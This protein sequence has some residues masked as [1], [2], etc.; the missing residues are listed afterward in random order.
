MTPPDFPFDH[1]II[2]FPDAAAAQ[3]AAQGPL[4]RLL[5]PQYPQVRFT[6]TSDPFDAR[7]GSGGGTAAALLDHAAKEE[8]VLILHAGG[9]AS[10][11]PT[12]MCLGKAWTSLPVAVALPEQPLPTPLDL[13]LQLCQRIFVGLPKG[14]V[15]VIA[16]DTL[17]QLADDDGSF[18]GRVDWSAALTKT[19]STIVGL[20][21]PAPLATAANHGVFVVEATPDDRSYTSTHS[22]IQPCRSVLQ[23][24]SVTTMQEGGCFVRPKDDELCA[25]IDTGVTIFSPSAAVTLLETA[26]TLLPRCTATGLRALYEERRTTQE[27]DA[28]TLQEFAVQN[29]VSVDLYTHILQ[30]LSLSNESAASRQ[31]RNDVFVSQYAPELSA[32]LA[33]A[34]WDAL[35]PVLFQVLLVPTGRFWHLGTT[36]ELR[37]FLVDACANR[38]STDHPA[39]AFGASL[40]LTRRVRACTTLGG[41]YMGWNSVDPSAVI[42]DSILSVHYEKWKADRNGT[43]EDVVTYSSIG[44]RTVVEHCDVEVMDATIR[45]GQ[46]C[47]VSGLRVP[48]DPQCRGDIVIP[49]NMVVQMVRLSKSTSQVEEKEEVAFVIIVLGINDEIK[50]RSSLYGVPVDTFLRRSGLS[51]QDVWDDPDPSC[52]TIWTAKIHPVVTLSRNESFAMVFSWLRYVDPSYSSWEDGALEKDATFI[53][54]KSSRRLALSEIRDMSDAP[55]EFQFREA[56]ITHRIPQFRSSYNQRLVSMLRERRQC[57][58]VDFQFL[59]DGYVCCVDADDSSI[60]IGTLLET[61]HAVDDVIRDGMNRDGSHDVGSRACM[62]E[63]NLLND[64]VVGLSSLQSTEKIDDIA[65]PIFCDPLFDFDSFASLRDESII[66]GRLQGISKASELLQGMAGSLTGRHVLAARGMQLSLQSQPPVH[67]RWV[68]AA[69]P[70]RIDL[71]GGWSDTPPICYEFGSLVVGMAVLIDGR[72]PLLCRCRI[73]LGGTGILLRTETRDSTTG[74]LTTK[75]EKEVT[76]MDGF[77]DYRNPASDCALL[78]CALVHLGFDLNDDMDFQEKVNAFCRSETVSVRMEIVATTTLPQGSGL[79]SSSI[80]AGCILAAVGKCVGAGS[81]SSIDYVHEIVD[82]VLNVEQY[83]TT[84]GGFQDQVNGLVGG[85]KAVSSSPNVFPMKIA[86]ENIS[87]NEEFRSELEERIILLF[88]GKTRLAKNL[89][90][91]VLTRWSKQTPEIIDAV[92]GLIDGAVKCRDS[93]ASRSVDL[94]GECLS[95]YWTFKRVMAGPSSGVEPQ[96]V[97]DVIRC[98]DSQGLIKGASLC[99]AGGG[100]FM[101]ILRGAG[102]SESELKQALTNDPNLQNEHIASFSWHD[103]K[104]CE[105]G[106]VVR[107]LADVN[108]YVDDFDIEWLSN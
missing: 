103:C 51:D 92:S 46:H 44:A 86:I 26:R 97:S 52:N 1:V 65:D 34:L 66:S 94:L 53:R 64:I 7:V 74:N 80:L 58:P 105:E 102:V 40:G 39:A 90:T 10:R 25:W 49:D 108:G 38:D 20:A 48:V 45:I 18:D 73:V 35:A 68:V 22:S 5:Q 85:M 60:S 54:W 76:S 77:M 19:A 16:S 61:L 72:R 37:D 91:Q 70:A 88:T 79:G 41:N 78:M 71:S 67:D 93:I 11:C 59:V 36:R 2:T 30:A 42:M 83:L 24:P 9:A 6:A 21:V 81:Q 13:W 104:L 106:L 29:A 4:R 56:L 28:I 12:Q 107:T 99:G 50:K 82:S 17:L 87:I 98:L 101:V 33:V 47:V 15:V 57:M 69:A 96:V 55:S 31:E 8:T 3:T 27:E 89:L 75:L 95:E 32:E 43:Q 62:I 100:G 63:S 23:K 14:S 84:G